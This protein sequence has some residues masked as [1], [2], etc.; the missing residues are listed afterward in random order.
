MLFPEGGVFTEKAFM[1]SSYDA[2][3]SFKGNVKITVLSANNAANVCEVSVFK[4]AEAEVLFRS[5]C[6]FDVVSKEKNLDTK[7]RTVW[8]VVLK[9]RP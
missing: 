2:E 4:K 5:G 1:S 3:K 8:N 7:G 6:E 9:E